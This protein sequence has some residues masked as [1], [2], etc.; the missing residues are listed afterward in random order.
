MSCRNP[1]DPGVWGLCI[2]PLEF[3]LRT[4]HLGWHNTARIPLLISGRELRESRRE[5]DWPSC[6]LIGLG[7]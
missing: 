7:H 5:A 6:G 1:P 3:F 4:H 2:E